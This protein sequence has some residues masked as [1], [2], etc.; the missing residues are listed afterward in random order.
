MMTGKKALKVA[1]ISALLGALVPTLVAMRMVADN[2]NNGEVYDTVTGQ[3]DVS[4]VLGLSAVFY[5]ASFLLIFGVVFGL[6]RL[7]SA[8]ADAS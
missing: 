1:A 6:A 8:D 4:Y 2:N 3:W 7:W 5:G